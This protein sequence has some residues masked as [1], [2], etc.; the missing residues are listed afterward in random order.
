MRP[1]FGASLTD[2]LG[3]TKQE[4]AT[5]LEVCCTAIREHGMDTEGL[6]RIA[7]GS[8]K[9]KFLKVYTYLQQ[10]RALCCAY[11]TSR[12][13]HLVRSHSLLSDVFQSA[14][15]AGQT[16][17]SAHDPHTIA[18]C[19]KMYLRELPEPLLTYE[20]YSDWMKAAG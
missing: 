16:D 19:L 11:D 4:I 2:H 3:N 1:V 18:G 14:F 12:N 6:F 13:S 15:D 7:A 10:F 20:L 17:V 8:S 9:V 5:V